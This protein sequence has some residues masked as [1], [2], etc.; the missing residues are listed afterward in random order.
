MDV[1]VDYSCEDN[2]ETSETGRTKLT[3]SDF[4]TTSIRDV[5]YAIQDA[6]QAPVCDQ[7]LF[8]QGQP[9]TDDDMPLS[10]LYF[11]EGDC[12]KLQFLAAADI[13]G[14]REL[15][16]VLKNFAQEIV[17]ILN[18][19]L[20]VV[21]LESLER[22]QDLSDEQNS[23]SRTLQ[24]LADQFLHPWKCLRSVAQ[25]HFFV[26]E[27]GFEAFLEVFKFS[28][29]LYTVEHSENDFNGYTSSTIRS[30]RNMDVYV[31]YSCE[32]NS[33][34]SETG[35]TKLTVS[36]FDTTSIRDVKY[37]I[38]DAIQ[39]PV[40]DQQLFHQGQPV[41]DDDMPL[42]RLYFREGDCFKL[43]F[44]AAADI[45]GM[46][47]LLDVLKNFAQEIVEILNRQLPVVNLESLERLQDLSDEQ[48]SVSR[49]L[50]K[51]ADQFLHPWKCLRS[52][53]QRHF[54]VQEG[55]FEAFLEVFKFSRQ[56]YTVEH[57]EN[58]F[59]GRVTPQVAFTAFPGGYGSAPPRAAIFLDQLKQSFNHGQLFLQLCCLGF[60]WNFGETP[61]DRKFLMSRDVFPLTVD[62]LLL[63]PPP[64][65]ET[66][67]ID[68]HEANMTIGVNEMAIGCCA[69]LAEYDSNIQEEMSKMPQ[70]IDKLLFLVDRCQ[71]E[72][73]GYSLY[74]SHVASN[75]MFYCTFNV[76][77]AQPLVDCGALEKMIN[78]TK[79]LLNDDD[80]STSLRYYCCLF[81]ARMR[82]APLVTQDRD[83][84]V[85]ID[86]LIDVFLDRHV[87][88][89]IS[90]WEEEN[91]Y[92]WITMMPLAHLAFAAGK[93]VNFD[94]QESEGTQCIL[95]RKRSD[96]NIMEM[97]ETGE[98]GMEESPK[99]PF[100]LSSLD[101][102][103]ENLSDQTSCK[104]RRIEDQLAT[105]NTMC[106][107]SEN[108][109]IE[110]SMSGNKN[111]VLAG[112][113]DQFTW[114]GSTSTQ[115]LG[116]FSLVHM[117][118]IKENQQLALSENL[119][120]YLVCL[121]WHLKCDEREKLRTS[122]ANFHNATTP[123]SLKVS[124]KSVLA[125]VNGLDMVFNI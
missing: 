89:E 94:G 67:H 102:S 42:S 62:A 19:Q 33:E 87:P 43:Q 58:D 44:L 41:T 78:I 124:A 121:S 115:K 76:K 8:H 60:L 97:V 116:I 80:S 88:D 85:V 27:G 91:S 120:P 100:P 105:A 68:R 59:N 110:T 50:Q 119:F 81:L 30:E 123:P 56:L 106:D 5:K 34:T 28:R 64:L 122:L 52:V 3:V 125:L 55:G 95:E 53:A 14:M 25:R 73:E 15:L 29:Q 75:I 54:F 92:V 112:K 20:P 61:Q 70:L 63:K 38:Q 47:E 51:L 11:R 37:A 22:L 18:R 108:M 77:S 69:A 16:D 96:T 83:T 98:A 26:Q 1:Y 101:N 45:P 107:I 39:A 21:N 13:P 6:I 109:A 7:Q 32:D 2:S 65:E 66:G 74:S 93:I 82:S 9:V 99:S 4:D 40:C 103:E 111:C 10:R 72:L 57:S 31:D 36:D 86:E 23:V 104:R 79:R 24:K 113:K 12:F 17:E 49:T 117:L 90:R 48:N 84:C 71:S 35:R 46:R 114:P 118:S